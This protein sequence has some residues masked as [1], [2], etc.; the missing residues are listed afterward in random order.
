[1][2]IF[3]DANCPLCQVAMQHLKRSDIEQKITLEDLNADDFSRRFPTVNQHQAMNILQAQTSSGQMIYGLDVTYQAWRSV[4][5]YPW[6]KIIRLPVIRFFADSVYRV[7]AKY[8]HHISR[9]LM[10]NSVCS[11]GQCSNKAKGEK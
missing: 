10:P 7:F 11:S 8:R 3:Y 4:G 6:L 2:I 9:F 1:M 5:K